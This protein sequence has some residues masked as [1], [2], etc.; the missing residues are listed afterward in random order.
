[1]LGSNEIILS[2][3]VMYE[4]AAADKRIGTVVKTFR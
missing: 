2:I 1:M 4:Q 3:E